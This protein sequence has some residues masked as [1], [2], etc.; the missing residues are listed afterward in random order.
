MPQFMLLF[1]GGEVENISAEEMQKI[2]E[3]YSAWAR[4]LSE[5]G[6]LKAGD[7]LSS[8]GRLVF[9]KDGKIVD[10]PFAE[11]KESIGGY[12]LID[13]KDMDEAIK[14]SHECP[15]FDYGSQ[16]EIRQIVE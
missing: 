7:E 11:T 6:C 4:K 14:I 10:G 12:F 15:A 3:K 8:E 16:V 13:V 1:R 9:R 5:N 2:V